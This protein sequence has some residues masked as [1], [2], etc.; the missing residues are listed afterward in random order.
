ML[1]PEHHATQPQLAWNDGSKILLQS[2]KPEHLGPSTGTL[3]CGITITC[4]GVGSFTTNSRLPLV[5]AANVVVTLE[6]VTM[7]A[8]QAHAT[9]RLFEESFEKDEKQGFNKTEFVLT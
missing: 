2:N 4:A 1:L 8:I 9:K 5:R 6:Q 3:E 7:S